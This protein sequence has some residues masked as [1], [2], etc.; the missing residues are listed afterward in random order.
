ML[1]QKQNIAVFGMGA[2]GSVVAFELQ[3]NISRLNLSYYN[4]SPRNSI[5]HKR[6]NEKVEIP[7][8]LE[9]NEE[10]NSH[11]DWL[12]VCI[13]EYDYPK[14]LIQFRN[15]ISPETKV[16]V[17]RNGLNLKDPFVDFTRESNILE[18]SID[19]PTESNPDGF[20]ESINDPIISVP[21][22]KLSNDFKALFQNSETTIHQI[23]DYNS[24]S[25][26]K[27]LESSALGSILCISGETAWIFRDEKVQELYRDILRE[28]VLVAKADGAKIEVNFI[29]KSLEKVLTYPHY[30]GS[31]MLRDR[32]KKRKIEIGAKNGIISEIGLRYGIK[33]PINDRT[34]SELNKIS[35][36]II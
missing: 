29:E 3:S 34:V 35:Q 33:T 14:A 24:V 1:Q 5:L 17:I 27:L 7:I 2:I 30:K 4:R 19:C 10:G 36:K 12:I 22:G 18:C 9:N 26:K 23:Q 8:H 16:A 31:S 15:L 6:R 11:L 21:I 28:G 20:Y 32:I 13:K 25:W